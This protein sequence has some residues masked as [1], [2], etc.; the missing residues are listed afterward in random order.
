MIGGVARNGHPRV[1]MLPTHDSHEL[2]PSVVESG[3]QQIACFPL[4]GHQTMMGV[5]C[6]ATGHPQP[7]DE[8]QI[9][10][11]TSISTWIAQ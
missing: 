6:V 8:L 9:Q 3:L 5:L 1:L 4:P 11:L 10:F 2:H 7:F